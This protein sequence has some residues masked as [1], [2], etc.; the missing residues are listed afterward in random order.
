MRPALVHTAALSALLVGLGSAAA[1]DDQPRQAERLE[2]R[3]FE[4]ERKLEEGQ[5]ES[6]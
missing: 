6:P 3:A 4:A 5:G 1:C 2:E